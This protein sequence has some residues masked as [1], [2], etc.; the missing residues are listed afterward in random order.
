M[1]KRKNQITDGQCNK[2]STKKDRERKGER[3]KHVGMRGKIYDRTK[4]KEQKNVNKNLERIRKE[5]KETDCESES[6]F[7]ILD[8][9]LG[10]DM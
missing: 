4:K 7:S 2:K 6:I 3:I 5:M 8:K 9:E 1:R 10:K